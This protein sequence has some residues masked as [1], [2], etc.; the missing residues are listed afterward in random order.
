MREHEKDDGAGTEHERSLG[1]PFRLGSRLEALT[2]ENPVPPE[3]A[4]D[5]EKMRAAWLRWADQRNLL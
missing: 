5:L 2:G 4:G 1:K 3:D